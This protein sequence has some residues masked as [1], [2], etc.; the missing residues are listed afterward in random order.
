MKCIE[1]RK[2]NEPLAL[3][4]NAPVSS[5][6]NSSS[7]LSKTIHSLEIRDLYSLHSFDSPSQEMVSTAS[8]GKFWSLDQQARLFPAQISDDSPWKQE[9]AT[10]RLDKDTE[11]R[12]QEALDLYFSRHHNVTT[13]EDVPLI[14]ASSLQNRSDIGEI[15]VF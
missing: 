1:S 2:E 4:Q 7:V 6:R 11:N 10:S 9:A 8:S 3:K 15:D 12:T 5:S 14:T 13:P